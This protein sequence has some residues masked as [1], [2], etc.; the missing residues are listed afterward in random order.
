MTH[1]SSDLF[2]NK[3]YY[4]NL[5]NFYGKQIS[6]IYIVLMDISLSKQNFLQVK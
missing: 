6:N 1:Q 4:L 5:T 2:N 3:N